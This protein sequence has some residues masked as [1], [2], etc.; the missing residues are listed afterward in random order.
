MFAFSFWDFHWIPDWMQGWTFM[1]I[2]GVLLVILI[3]VLIVMRNR[4]AEED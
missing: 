1:G 2:M 3:V 4:Q